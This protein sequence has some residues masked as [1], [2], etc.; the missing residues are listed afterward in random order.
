ML[1]GNFLRFSENRGAFPFGVSEGGEFCSYSFS[2]TS[3][4]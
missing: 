1:P 3:V 2:A 4:R